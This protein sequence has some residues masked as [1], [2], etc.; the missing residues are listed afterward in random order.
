MDVVCDEIMV[1]CLFS[2]L[3]KKW[4]PTHIIKNPGNFTDIAPQNRLPQRERLVFQLSFFR[5]YVEFPWCIYIHTYYIYIYT[6][7]I[8][9]HYISIRIY[10]ASISW[11]LWFPKASPKNRST[12]IFSDRYRSNPSD[13]SGGMWESVHVRSR[14]QR[15][16]RFRRFLRWSI[17]RIFV[18]EWK[19]NFIKTPMRWL[20][21]I[22]KR[23]VGLVPGEVFVEN[24]VVSKRISRIKNKCFILSQTD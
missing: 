10:R 13:P 14:F 4:F 17:G 16:Q 19:T 6:Y 12:H 3:G 21:E 5:G 23:L 24:E 8:I 11:N 1:F 22:R 7:P 18:Q 9:I 20:V 2:L 15:F